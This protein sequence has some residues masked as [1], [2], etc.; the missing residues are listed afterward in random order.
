M[1]GNGQEPYGSGAYGGED[2][3]SGP[4]GT[5]AGE[6]HGLIDD[7]DGVGLALGGFDGT[8]FGVI[9]DTNMPAPV[10][11]GWFAGTLYAGGG[12]LETPPANIQID[13]IEVLSIDT[14][15]LTFNQL[16]VNDEVLSDVLSYAV[17]PVDAGVSVTVLKVVP[18]A[19]KFVSSVVL[20]TTAPTA[21]EPYSITITGAILNQE[22][23]GFL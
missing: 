5:H 23:R 11:K 13:S 20:Y 8:L 16:I 7:I 9:G 4:A 10:F 12:I 3:L 6:L 22:G 14:Y 17:A 18:D 21:E 19:G 1:S 15:R 2:L